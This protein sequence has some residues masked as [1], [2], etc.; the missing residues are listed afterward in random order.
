MDL[1]GFIIEYTM[2]FFFFLSLS[3]RLW[4][5]QS[6]GFECCSNDVH[7]QN[8]HEMS[9][10]FHVQI[11]EVPGTQSKQSFNHQVISVLPFEYKSSVYTLILPSCLHK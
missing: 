9:P 11:L 6:K 7:V 3:L 1:K 2:S 5:P 4:D 8:E 10:L